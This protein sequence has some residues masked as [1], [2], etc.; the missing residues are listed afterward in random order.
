[1]LDAVMSRRVMGVVDRL[2]YWIVLGDGLRAAEMHRG[3]AGYLR[4]ESQNHTAVI[5]ASVSDLTQ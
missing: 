3:L 5:A 4:A 1:M 2:A